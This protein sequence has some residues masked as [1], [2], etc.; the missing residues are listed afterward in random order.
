MYCDM[1]LSELLFCRPVSAYA[2]IAGDVM[3][4]TVGGITEFYQTDKGVIV[5]ARIHGLPNQT[6]MCKHPIFAFHIHAGNACTG[7]KEDPFANSMTHYDPEHCL[8]PYHAG[9]MPPLFSNKGLAIQ[10][11]LTDRF[12][13][14]EIIGKTVIIHSGTDDFTTQPSG[15]AGRKIAC[16]VIVEK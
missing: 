1:F 13:V 4:P 9:N 5:A 11:F 16:G 8:H 12:T 6:G 3:H 14:R 15:N 7:T 2:K 10:V